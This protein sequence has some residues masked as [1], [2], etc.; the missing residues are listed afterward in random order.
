VWKPS[1]NSPAL[2]HIRD[3]FALQVAPLY[4]YIFCGFA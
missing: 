4:P 3:G 1:Y 2:V